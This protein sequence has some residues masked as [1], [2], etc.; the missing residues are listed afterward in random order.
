MHVQN[1][2]NKRISYT[3]ICQAVQRCLSF[4]TVG[5]DSE[6]VYPSCLSCRSFFLSFILDFQTSASL[7]EHF[8]LYRAVPKWEEERK[9]RLNRR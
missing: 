3:L 2:H 7:R 1:N 5:I 6:A 9:G 4:Q 8:S